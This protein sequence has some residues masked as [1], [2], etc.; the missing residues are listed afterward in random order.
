MKRIMAATVL[1]ASLMASYPHTSLAQDTPTN[2]TTSAAPANPGGIS[3]D[4]SRSSGFDWGW[5]GLLGLFGL[6]G[7][8]GRNR[9]T[10]EYSGGRTSGAR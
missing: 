4:N 9:S 2:S 10:S 8:R 6:A 7:L 1:V 3:S 5:L